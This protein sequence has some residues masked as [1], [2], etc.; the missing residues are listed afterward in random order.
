MLCG[1]QIRSF[2]ALWWKGGDFMVLFGGKMVILWCF[3]VEKWWVLVKN[4]A[5]GGRKKLLEG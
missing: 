4:S 5:L 1:G 2:G 3:V